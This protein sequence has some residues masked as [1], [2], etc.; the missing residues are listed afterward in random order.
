MIER[1]KISLPIILVLFVLFLLVFRLYN[2][3]KTNSLTFNQII[4]HNNLLSKKLVDNF[5]SDND[6]IKELSAESI[7]KI[8]LENLGYE[9]WLNY[10]DFIDIHLYFFDVV[11]DNTE[12]LIISVNLSQDQGVI[13]IYRLLEDK[14]VLTSKIDGLCNIKN[15]TAFRIEPSKKAFILTEELLDEMVGAY[16]V[17]SFIRV[18]S[19]IENEFVE[20]FRQSIDYTAYYYE[21][22]GEPNASDPKWYKIIESS[23]VDNIATEKEHITINVSKSLSKF[24]AINSTSFSI[25][26]DYKLIEQ[27]SFDI[28]FFWSEL[29]NSFIISEGKIISKNIEVGILE[30][31][32][33]TVDYLLNLTGKYY[34]VIDENKRILFIDKDDIIIIKDFST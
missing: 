2:E 21:K 6:E 28:K 9:N 16:F 31:T 17:D 25:P 24:E 3:S 19:G 7:K 11:H 20:V 1:K 8:A 30:D 34:K 22:W 12:D 4:M 33:Q 15:I 18:F 32:A 14:Y 13:G 26:N 5:F 10:I 27:N 23:V 29:Y